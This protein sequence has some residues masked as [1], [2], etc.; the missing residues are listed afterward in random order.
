[1]K[2][3]TINFALLNFFMSLMMGLNIISIKPIIEEKKNLGYRNKLSQKIISII[4][5]NF[6][7]ENN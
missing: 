1:M 6:L 7:L 5:L 3:I 4:L 2:I